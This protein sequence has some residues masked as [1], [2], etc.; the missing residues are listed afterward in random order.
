ML[1]AVTPGAAVGLRPVPGRRVWKGSGMV[2]AGRRMSLPEPE[3]LAL[4][5]AAGRAVIAA[6]ILASPVRTVR[7]MGADTATAARVTWLTRMMG[8]RDAAIGVGGV[9]ALRGKGGAGGPW[10]LAGAASDAVDALVIAGA[11]KRGR[12]KGIVP[13]AIVPLAAGTAAVGAV[14]ALRLRRH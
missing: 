5:I 14:T 11:L 7:M 6:S 3:A 9:A 8:A 12:V 2:I 10:L 13:A 1:G 4:Q